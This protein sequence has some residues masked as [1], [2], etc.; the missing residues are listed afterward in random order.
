MM[1][2]I[3][4]FYGIGTNYVKPQRGL[5]KGSFFCSSNFTY[6]KLLTAGWLELMMLKASRRGVVNHELLIGIPKHI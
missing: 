4:D 2:W 3:D 5:P 6:H 1:T